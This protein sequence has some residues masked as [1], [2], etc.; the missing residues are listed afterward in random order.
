VGEDLVF[1]VHLKENQHLKY[2]NNCST[3]TKA[4]FHAIPNG[5]IGRLAKLTS[6]TE[7]TKSKRIDEL[8]PD[9]AKALNNARLAPEQYPTL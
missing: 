6:C 5:V 4:V 7:D 8:Y 3:H 9:H 1:G 2:L